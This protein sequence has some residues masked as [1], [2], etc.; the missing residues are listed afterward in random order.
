VSEC[1]SLFVEKSLTLL[2]PTFNEALNINQCGTQIRNLIELLPKNL[3]VRVLFIDNYSTDDSWLKI[4]EICKNED[5]WHGIR[6]SRNY[7]IQ[8]S[9]LRGMSLSSTDAI[10]VFQSD[11]QDPINVAAELVSRWMAGARVVAGIASKRSEAKL[12][13]WPRD[14]FYRILK[15]SSDQGMVPGFHDFYVLDKEVYSQLMRQGYH[16]EF[17]RGRIAEEFGIDEIVFYD[18]LP[19]LNGGTSFNFFRKYSMAMDGILRHG[20]RISRYI[21]LISLITSAIS[22]IIVGMI[23]LAYVFGYRAASPG[24]S[25]LIVIE[26]VSFSVLT[27]ALSL[28]MEYLFRILRLL[29]S[30]DHPVILNEF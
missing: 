3:E 10:L 14:L 13:S 2:V 25:S 21:G 19:R 17:I 5:S 11:L 23:L 16:H 9:L 12:D 22:L 29:Q 20:S 28:I 27:F 30:N 18:R 7:G 6:L 15:G 8:A 26:L 24:W 1:Y 4:K